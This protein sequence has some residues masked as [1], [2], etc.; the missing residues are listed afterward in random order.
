MKSLIKPMLLVLTIVLGAALVVVPA[1]AQNGSPVSV[2][3]P[4]DFSVGDT[5]LKAGNYKIA[6]LES[7][8]LLFS[9]EDGNQHQVA[10]TLRGD[11][12]N[13]GQTP[14]LLL[15]RYGNEVFL[16]KVFLSAGDECNNLV[17]SSREKMLKRARGEEL[18]LLIR[19]AR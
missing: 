3:I 16:S 15:T 8:I 7:G 13:Q 10:F 17:R 18:S 12:V 1:R 6:Q 5:P 9:S 4:F 19:P 11:S 2:N 14:H